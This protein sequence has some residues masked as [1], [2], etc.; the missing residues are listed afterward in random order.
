MPE[1]PKAEYL[2]ALTT[3]RTAAEA[4]ALVRELVGRRVIACGTV[5]PGGVSIYR[6]AG[7]VTEADEVIVLMKT[8]QER[9][10]ALESSIRERHPYDVPE[11]LAL[12]VDAG[13]GSYL[14]WLAA[15]TT[16]K[17]P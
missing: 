11:L 7:E 15:E 6:W 2:V 17:G 16:E 3:L 9:W 1:A 8:R 14:D 10:P 12:P 5:L 4:R 13:L